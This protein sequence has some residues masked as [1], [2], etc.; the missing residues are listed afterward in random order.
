VV[1]RVHSLTNISMM[2]HRN[3]EINL[4][5]DRVT[6]LAYDARCLAGIRLSRFVLEF[7]RTEPLGRGDTRQLYRRDHSRIEGGKLEYGLT[8]GPRAMPAT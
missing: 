3:N 8:S 4:P 1:G 7:A 2:T 5:L 6:A